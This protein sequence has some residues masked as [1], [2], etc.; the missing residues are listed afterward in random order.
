MCVSA[1]P[2]WTGC[3]SGTYR[4]VALLALSSRW[5]PQSRTLGGKGRAVSTHP[6]QGGGGSPGFNT[7]H[8]PQASPAPADP[9]L[10]PVSQ[11]TPRSWLLSQS[12]TVRSVT[13]PP[14]CPSE[15]QRISA[16]VDGKWGINQSL[17]SRKLPTSPNPYLFH[18]TPLTPSVPN[19]HSPELYNLTLYGS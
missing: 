6:V 9:T 7:R 16:C 15:G 8:S 17:N 10:P 4:H 2:G 13:D 14:R 12:R 1:V 11:L 18:N 19:T 3:G 5:R